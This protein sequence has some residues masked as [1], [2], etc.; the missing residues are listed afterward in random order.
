ME[1]A[2]TTSGGDLYAE[3]PRLVFWE[4][5]K[6]CPLACVHC[7]AAA[8]PD[9]LP[10]ELGTAEGLALID[11]LATGPRSHPVLVL[12]G[13][14]C[15][16]RPDLLELAA[17]ARRVGVP[18]AIA[19]SV[20]P[21]LAPP[22]LEALRELG[23]KHAS[24]SLDGAVARTHE[25]IRQ[26]AGHFQATL[27]AI[28]LLAGC[29]FTVQVNT[30]VMSANVDELADIAL[31]LREIGVRIWEVFFL[32]QVGR[33]DDVT[34]LSAEQCEEVCH[35]L[36][37]AAASGLVVRTVEA[38]FYRRVQL[39][40]AALGHGEGAAPSHG[41][42]H[43]R[44]GATLRAGLGAP[45]GPVLPPTAATRDGKGVIF[46]AHDGDVYPSG[47]LPLP[48]GNVRHAGLLDI[49]R[50]HPVLR[51]IR[52]ARFP[53]ACGR[54]RHRDL[55]GGSRARAFA[56][57]GDPLGDDDACVEAAARGA[58]PRANGVASRS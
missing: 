9:A 21:R 26:V 55:C 19:P 24:V 48:L 2:A 6:A 11:E 29:G 16:S 23:V 18:L 50:D 43:R 37:D 13:G 14:D 28:G 56:T 52:A 57:F 10:G 12:T 53:G 54:C 20:S 49:Y 1:T 15:L 7:R 33:G 25:G 4:T 34:A 39:E 3:Q 8:Q 27:D 32:V 35:F 30:A 58:R 17:H 36:V 5:T 51:D 46:V 22:L 47:F 31:L 38:P 44:L 45:P 41:E 42:L 40:R